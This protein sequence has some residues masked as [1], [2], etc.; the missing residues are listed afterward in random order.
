M[1]RLSSIFHDIPKE[2]A[3]VLRQCA[4]FLKQLGQPLVAAE[5]YEKIEDHWAH[6]SLYIDLKQWD[7]VST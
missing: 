7:M 2:E 3:E 5:V 6:I 4:E 1:C